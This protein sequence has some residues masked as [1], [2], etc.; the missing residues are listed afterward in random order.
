LRS[1]ARD[2][3]GPGRQ[4]GRVAA[5]DGLRALAVSAVLGFHGGLSFLGGGFLG[6]DAFFVL[7][8]YLI[9][10]LLLAE[11]RR[12]GRVDLP[13]FWA[14][15][16]RR[17]LPALVVVVVAVAA[18]A[19]LLVTPTEARLVR[20]DALA[21]LLYVANWRMTWRG[22]DYFAQTAA[23]SPLQHTWS[24]GIEEQFYLVWPLA[25]VA[26]LRLR[27]PRRAVAALCVLGGCAS[28]VAAA[29]LYR[30]GGQVDRVYFGTDTRAVALLVGAALAVALAGPAPSRRA[31]PPARASGAVALCGAALL[32]WAV[33]HAEGSAVSLYRGGL[34]A[35]AI[36]VAAV[37]AHAVLVP[38]GL[39]ARLLSVPPLP[40]LGRISY[41]VYLWHWPVFVGLNGARTGLSGAG[42]LAA[43]CLVTLLLAGP[44]DWWNSRSGATPGAP[45]P[46]SPGA[47][48]PSARP[49]S[50][51][52]WSSPVRAARHRS[53]VRADRRAPAPPS[54]RCP[55]RRVPPRPRRRA[56]ATATP[57]RR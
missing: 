11:W 12:D 15:R 22:T 56:T 53:T 43:R 8:G 51:S 40:A 57:A 39:T 50:W 2:R 42:L 37:I 20:G 6:V 31:A 21:A 10:G 46:A 34:L 24:L 25:L 23:P 52:R 13:A 18:C 35:V 47:S 19:H 1:A 36:A 28:L 29:V 4:D 45:V 55:G 54:P 30:P 33:T 32:A 49:A 44:T 5:L 16:A 3:D 9:T 48:P 7:S 27:R 41:G 17:L 38:G 26:L 14:R